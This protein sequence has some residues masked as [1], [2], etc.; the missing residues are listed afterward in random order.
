MNLDG[1]GDQSTL[2]RRRPNNS[3]FLYLDAKFG[4][5]GIEEV[6]P[7]LSPSYFSSLSYYYAHN[8]SST[9][10]LFCHSGTVELLSI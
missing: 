3:E 4:K 6:K 9:L 1:T 10:K 7:T 5:S 2:V 8:I